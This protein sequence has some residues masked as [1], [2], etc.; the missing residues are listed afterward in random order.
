M[1]GPRLGKEELELEVLVKTWKKTRRSNTK[2]NT[3]FEDSE[4][5]TESTYKNH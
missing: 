1:R 2:A 5:Y 3:Q 4:K